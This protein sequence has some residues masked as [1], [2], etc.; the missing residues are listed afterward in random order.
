MQIVK[1]ILTILGFK[2]VSSGL[3]SHNNI[4]AIVSFV[5][6]KI[7]LTIN[8]V[9]YGIVTLHKFT[10]ILSDMGYSV[11]EFNSSIDLIGKYCLVEYNS[12][13][14]RML[15]N[16][17]KIVDVDIKRSWYYVEKD[18]GNVTIYKSVAIR[19]ITNDYKSLLSIIEDHIKMENEISKK[20]EEI[21]SLVSNFKN[22]LGEYENL[23]QN[24]G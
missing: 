18:R 14:S 3:Y 1:Q 16:I 23:L 24:K 10:S 9:D 15:N 20:Y 7:A 22:K 21:N 8:D 13:T 6:N 5:D 11:D 2:K 12:S 4:T 17:Y 19:C